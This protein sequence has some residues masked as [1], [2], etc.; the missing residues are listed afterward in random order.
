MDLSKS[1]LKNLEEN[2]PLDK[3][4]AKAAVPPRSVA[5]TSKITSTRQTDLLAIVT[6]VA[7]PRSTKRGDV[8]DV[9]LMDASEDV[10]GMYAKVSVSV[11][12]TAKQKLLAIGKPLVFLNLA[13]KV[14][15]GCKQFNHWED[16]MLCGAPAC[17]KHNELTKNF[18]NI[19]DATNTVT[20]TKFTPKTSMDVSGPQPLAVCAFLDFTSE[21]PAANVPNV[22]QIMCNS[23]EEPTGSVTCQGTDRI[24]FLTKMRDGSG[25][26]EVGVPERVALQLTGLDRAGFL[27]AHTV[28]TLQFPL[29]C[30]AR[31]SRSVS[32]GASRESQRGSSQPGASQ[33]GASQPGASAAKTF[34]NHVI[35]EAI[36]IDWSAAVAP[37]AAYESILAM[38]NLFPRHED[39]IVFAYLSDIAA[40]PHSGFRLTFDNGTTSKGAAV[41]V[42]IAAKKKSKTPEAIG[43]G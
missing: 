16:S 12:G 30:N 43:Q 3:Q 27:E 35:Q 41:A 1:V 29:L 20:L 28:G 6:A 39:G 8:V 38:L 36:P 15:A 10:P 23:L 4:L 32:T 5:E 22:T 34:V 18:D 2:S 7:P 37:N 17:D 21:N 25:S 14:D 31:V 33:P 26:A 42:L 11:W 40:D 24:W 9:T 13:C 19:K